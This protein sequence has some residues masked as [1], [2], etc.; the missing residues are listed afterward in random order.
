MT[1]L[2]SEKLITAV[3]QFFKSDPVKQKF[4]DIICR[5]MSDRTLQSLNQN[6]LQEF[7]EILYD[8]FIIQHNTGSEIYFGKPKLDSVTLTNRLVL[9]MSQPDAA[10]L[11][12][13]IEEIFRKYRLRTSRRIHPIIGIKRDKN[14]KIIDIVRPNQSFERRSLI[15]VAFED[16]P[17][18]GLLDQIK[19]E[20]SFHMNCVQEA[21][22]D[23][24]HIFQQI[25]FVT[26]QL[27]LIKPIISAEWIKLLNWLTDQNFSFF[28][29]QVIERNGSRYQIKDSF[30]ICKKTVG[31]PGLNTPDDTLLTHPKNTPFLVDRT[32]VN[33]P[34]QRFEPLMRVSF[35]FNTTQYIFYGILKR[36][37]MYAKNID[38]PIIN[39]KMDHIFN[40]RHFLPGSYDFNEVIRIFNDIPKFELFRTSPEDLLE[41][42]DFIMSITNLNHIQCFKLS[43]SPQ[44]LKLYFVI[45][46]YL[47]SPRTIEVICDYIKPLLDY[48]YYD[49]LPITAPEK[50]RVHM[51]FKLNKKENLPSEESLERALTILVQPWE[52]QVRSILI[53]SA[54]EIL[55]NDPNVIAKIPTHYRAR[56]KPESAVRDIQHLLGFQDTNDIHFDF[57]SFDYPKSSDLAGKASMLLMYH[58]T[59][60]NLTEILPIIHN[61]GIYVIDQLTSRFGDAKSTIGYIL[62]FRLLNSQKQKIN[63][64]H[65][66]DRLIDALKQV[67][68]NSLPND[69]L[70]Q[71]ILSTS[72]NA[73]AIFL[74]QGLRNYLY[75]LF[76]SSYSIAL[77]NQTFTNHPE[78]LEQISDLFLS[79]FNPK[80]NKSKR[81]S[82]IIS[83]NDQLSKL[84]RG[85]QDI[86]EDQILSRLLSIVNACVRTNYYIKV[87]G[88]ALSYKFNC[89]QIFG[90]QTPVPFR[91]TFVF[92]SSL[93]GVH[94]R[95]GAV[96]RGGLRWS[97]R[98]DDY[99]TEVLGL[100]KTQ[101]TK[102]AVIIPVGSKGGF[103]IKT[104]QPDYDTGVYQY[105]RFIA[106]MLQLADNIVNGKKQSNNQL[107]TYDDFDPYF[108]VAADK[109]TATFSDFANQVSQ[110][111]KFWLGDGFASGGAHGYDHKKVGITAKGAWEC[112]KLHFQA[113]NLNPEKDEV[114]VVGVGDM[115]G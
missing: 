10:N 86:S 68:N 78:F 26:K 56:T 70:N 39:K 35:K 71:L 82:K 88:D 60:I 100:V 5:Q 59:K 104:P 30:G 34:I 25:N 53:H 106:S 63:E 113:M 12:I 3:K 65:V 96:A 115:S 31:I 92:D 75:Q 17:N 85:V 54:P 51:H 21:Q 45:P 107:I 95:F 44:D 4:I 110:D 69:P 33:S 76:S 114:S 77:I 55:E 27:Q 108:V 42:V 58:Q 102:N 15:F 62:A 14:G 43:N 83:L 91:E 38:T 49:V 22:H 40:E 111:Q 13:T 67:F 57:F 2:N 84:I 64:A 109:G 37:S 50:C 36:S 6:D 97:T 7:I 9:K 29:C 41:M 103:V 16:I 74:L 81:L 52:E 99:R 11:F 79:K 19:S 24:D 80:L 32:F 61:L 8:F 28:G 47:F 48:S 20:I 90:I 1:S 112:T 93:E 72:L 98:L 46:Y 18:Q 23:A 89:E 94:I 101:Q 66:K 73:D 105:K 87:P